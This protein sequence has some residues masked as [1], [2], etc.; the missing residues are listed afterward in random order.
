RNVM[1]VRVTDNLLDFFGGGLV[2]EVADNRPRVE[3][4]SLWSLRHCLL[5]SWLPGRYPDKVG[6]LTQPL[7]EGE[8]KDRFRFL[9]SV[10]YS[11]STVRASE[12]A[13]YPPLSHPP[14]H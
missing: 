12:V 14:F 9:T 5:I 1:F 7:P 6:T 3:D 13:L 10:P 11:R 4:V 2:L 8:E